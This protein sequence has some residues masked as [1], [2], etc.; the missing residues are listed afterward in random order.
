M[1]LKR[2]FF[3]SDDLDDLERLEEELEK[4]GIATAQIHVLTRDDSGADRRPH[5]N[6]V[7]SLMK[8]DLVHSTIIGAVVGVCVSMLVLLV[9][10]LA[11]WANS[12]YGWM[13]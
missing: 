4:A 2:H 6:K 7:V 1:K 8:R 9:V 12:S 5:L 10:Y 3:I 13:P 11:G